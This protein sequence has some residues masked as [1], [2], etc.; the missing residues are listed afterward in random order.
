V[1]AVVAAV[2]IVAGVGAFVAW[3]RGG[4]P[5]TRTEA[6]A[7]LRDR[8]GAER[9]RPQSA[10]IPASGVYTYSSTGRETVKLGPLPTEARPY[11]KTMYVTVVDSVEPECW[12]TTLNLLDQHTEDTTYCA[13]GDGRLR[14]AEHRKHQQVGALKPT[15]T[16][17]C[18]PD[19]ISRP[20]ATSSELA[21]SLTLSTGPLDVHASLAGTSRVTRNASVPV[22]GRDVAAV[23]VDLRYTVTGDLTGSWRER[24]WLAD[25]DWL[26]LRIE[27]ALDLKGLA[28]FTEQS[29]LRLESRAP[30]G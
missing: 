29:K 23:L 13:D 2:V 7:D 6:L 8:T 1:G 5:V 4:T 30:A 20:K 16:M 28:T 27:R 21:C 10:G 18:D 22:D 15:A 12:V 11:A 17:T 9:E 24:L 26:P 25:D 14:I 3:P 19:L